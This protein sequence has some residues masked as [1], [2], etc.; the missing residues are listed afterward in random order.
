MQDP[1]NKEATTP[2]SSPAET[3]IAPAAKSD[4][5]GEQRVPADLL[6]TKPSWVVDEKTEPAMPPAAPTELP[7]IAVAPTETTPPVQK[8]PMLQRQVFSKEEINAGLAA[9]IAKKEAEK[10]A[11]NAAE[12]ANKKWWQFWKK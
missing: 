5:A 8:N 1:E 3:I 4:A 11:A 12:Q 10:A 6:T 9:E 7:E 2:E